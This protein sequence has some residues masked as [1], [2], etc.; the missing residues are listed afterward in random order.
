MEMSKSI[1]TLGAGK[2]LHARINGDGTVGILCDVGGGTV[3]KKVD[4][5]T[6]AVKTGNAVSYADICVFC[7]DGI[8]EKT[9]D[10]F[11]FANLRD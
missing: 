4:S 9:A 11:T 5:A 7:G 1:L 10:G 8:L 6:R 2:V 3:V